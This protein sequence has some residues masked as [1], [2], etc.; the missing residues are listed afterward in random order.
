MAFYPDT[1][2]KNTVIDTYHESRV[3][4]IFK[5]L[6][7]HILLFTKVHAQFLKLLITKTT[8]VLTTLLCF[9]FLLRSHKNDV[10]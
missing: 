8:R 7:Y 4:D 10:L 2:I 5:V 9:K 1:S 6:I 3:N